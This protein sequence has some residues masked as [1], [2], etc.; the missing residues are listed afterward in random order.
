MLY[1][2]C[3]KYFL[4]VE[5]GI[6]C[7]VIPVQAKS[8]YV[9]DIVKVTLRTGPSIQ[10]KIIRMVES[11]QKVEVLE[12][13]QEWN[14]V[15]LDDGKEGWI[16]KR[17]LIANETNKL[18]LER[19]DSEHLDVK[20]KFKILIQENA[21]LKSDNT[22]LGSALATTEK[23]LEEVRNDYESLKSS[24]TEFLTL[25]SNFEKTS[26]QLSEQTKRADDLEEKVNKLAFSN[27]IRWFLAGSGVLFVGFILGFITKRPRRQSSLL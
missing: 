25:K 23:A 19:L 5:I 9:T 11:G 8:M 18:K 1:K 22:K 27:Y 6:I 12:S 2:L 14:L 13:G 16:L 21:K 10:N 4:L 15:R 3:I 17:Y 7:A 24:S 20:A 26:T